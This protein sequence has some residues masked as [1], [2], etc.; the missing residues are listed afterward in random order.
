MATKFSLQ[1]GSVD[2]FFTAVSS[3]LARKSLYQKV[4]TDIASI[5]DD[6]CNTVSFAR[7][8]ISSPNFFYSFLELLNLR[9]RDIM[10]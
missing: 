1:N 10:R 8:S 3:K 7:V 5:T 9:F 2:N 4:K 6:S